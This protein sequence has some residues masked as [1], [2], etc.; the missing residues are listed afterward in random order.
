M[1]LYLLRLKRK[2]ILIKKVKMP[3]GKA[4]ERLRK[5]PF[6]IMQDVLL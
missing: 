6:L 4:M 3:Y 1:E 2:Y 5:G